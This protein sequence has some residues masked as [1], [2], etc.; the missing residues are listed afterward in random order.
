MK[1]T[2]LL[3]AFI[4]LLS[5]AFAQQETQLKG[6]V[7]DTLGKAPLS[8][9]VIA[10]FSKKDSTLLQFT[11]S[12]QDGTFNLPNIAKG[13]YFVMVTF[14]KFA[15]YVD[16]VNIEV[17]IVDMGT[18]ALTQ[19]ATLLQEVVI[20]SGRA[21]RIKGDTTE[22]VADSFIVKEGA[23]VEDLL[24]KF[25]GFQVDSKGQITAHGQK[26]QKVLVDGE[27][28]FGDDPTMATQNISAKAV[29]K[30]QVFDNKSDQEQLKGL[31]GG[32]SQGKTVNIKL[33]ENS[34]KG[35][36]G[37]AF[38]GSDFQKY[39][40]A[41][42]YYNRFIGKKKISV[43]G[44]KST[45]STGSLN[46]EERNKLG[47]EN[48][49]EYD[50]INGYYFSIGGG[51]DFNDWNLR[52][53][54]DSYTAGALFINKWNEDKHGINTSYRYNRLST[55][56]E[57]S[58]L[59]QTILSNGLLYNNRFVKSNGL[60]QQHALNGKYEWKLD[61]L[62]SFK[63][64]T[65][66]I[67]KTTQGFNRTNSESLNEQQEYLNISEQIRT[68]ETERK[69][70]DNQLTYKQ[71][72]KKKDRQLLVT[73]RFGLIEDD[74]EGKLNAV[75]DFYKNNIVDSVGIVD[76]Q[77][78]FTGNSQTIGSKI[79]FSEPLSSKWSLIAE[80]SFNNNNSTSE[81]SSFNRGSNGKYE[82]LDSLYSNNFDLDASSHTSMAVLKYVSKKTRFAFGSGL[83]AIQLDLHDLEKSSRNKYNFLN[84]TPQASYS[85]QL[86]Q[87]SSFSFNYKG[88]TMQPSINQLQPLRDNNDPLNIFIGN[89]DLKVGFRHNINTY[90]Y[91][92]KV[93][94]GTYLSLGASFSLMQNAITNSSIIDKQTGKRTYSP[95]N[96]NGNNNWNLW[97]YW[98]YGQGEKKLRHSINWDGSGGRNINFINEEKG[99]NNSANFGLGYSISYEVKEKFN[100]NIGP[101]VGY[102]SSRSSL[103]TN[104]NNNYFS[105][106]GNAWGYVM[107]PGKIE[108]SSDV[109]A[110]LRQR[111][112]AFDRN[113]NIVQ[114][115]ASI[116]KKV[117]K[118]KSGKIIFLA[119]DILNQNKG[120]NR[121]I[122]S[123]FVTDE[124]YLRVSRY[125][126]LKFEWSFN[127]MPTGK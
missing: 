54:P 81:R 105:Y 72:F 22:Y 67:Y 29:D 119:N 74:Q 55:Q 25:P 86:K 56:N 90:F 34:K 33:K 28:F 78:I 117:L 115:N 42:A 110:N 10:L 13:K 89:P 80:Y 76:Q 66:G 61:S 87:Q 69:Q 24:K 59:T 62:A 15:D 84:L 17:P 123:N 91:N 44:S 57:S 23:T 68:N 83:S 85:Y 47:I 39:H 49:I 6:K 18:I 58:T 113:T 37:K 93:L 21:I 73:L 120:F 53:L 122:N 4:T 114:W 125:F 3:F 38:A 79:T 36:F 71:L 43:Y 95:I 92:S 52:G 8:Q 109:N 116:S 32:G 75:T 88:T 20:Q 118:D 46:W 70:L 12:K 5:H 121:I 99:I 27:E 45:V 48:D 11:R 103:Q 1:K 107:L 19:K 31:G 98:S 82:V 77:K 101:R 104:I 30:V 35:S 64:T 127:K 96:V 16:D 102:N 50:E 124:R 97:G 60:N 51:D 7:W 65:A 41:K 112:A 111:I 126:L 40:D 2:L 100:I 14:P 106:G 63:F 26:V 9:A 108:I 94:T